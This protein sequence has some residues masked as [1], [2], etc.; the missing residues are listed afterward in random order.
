MYKNNKEQYV[1]I[2]TQDKQL[3]I[4]YKI[5]QDKKIVKQE[6]SSFLLNNNEISKDAIFKLDTL[7]KDINKTYLSTLYTDKNQVIELNSQID[8]NKYKSV[9]LNEKISVAIPTKDIE[10]SASFFQTSG[11]DYLLSPFSILNEHSNKLLSKNS[12]N[13]L[14]YN[15]MVYALI[16]DENKEI[17]KGYTQSLTPFDNIK[18][19]NFYGDD[20]VGQKL[21][22]EV[23]FLELQQVISE[24]IEKYYEDVSGDEETSFLEKL[25]IFYNVK[26]LSDEQIEMIHDLVMIDINYTPISI[27]ES[28]DN[29]IQKPTVAN[30]SFL[31]ARV[32]KSTNSSILWIAL[33]VMTILTIGGILFYKISNTQED[34]KETKTKVEKVKETTKIE[35][36]EIVETVIKL[37]NHN[38]LNTKVL[39]RTLMF[40][41]LIPFD[42][43]L[44]ELELRKN[45]S[46]FVC[47]FAIDSNASQEM[48]KKLSKI[49]DESKIILQHNNKA[50]IST[51]I[52]NDGYKALK[53]E[54]SKYTKL[55]Y[56][57]HEFMTIS[58]FTEYL[59]SI[60]IK[61]SNV[62]YISKIQEKFITYNYNITSLVNTP[63]EFFDFIAK[64]NKKEIPLN[65]KYPVEFAKVKDKI[66]IK[67]NLQ[68]HQQK[69]KK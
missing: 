21:Y 14:L 57:K 68:F 1:N 41:D 4:D 17:N 56:Q 22:E 3:K 69:K 26:Q 54:K 5:L 7:Q 66:E 47:N 34:I 20:I 58:K 42:A 28:F 30:Y 6:V 44:L 67:F 63:K 45:S 31:S 10:R 9:A 53:K 23:Y 50:I 29:L 65:I 43:V 8:K 62:K 25:N 59:N 24:I 15:N 61:D 19:S 36:K 13:I 46:T 60:V 2:L 12:L 38:L 39:E 27:E 18:D 48:I 51:I 37:P 33:L 52:S 64:L 11:L 55:K 49:Y 16:L 40:F 35:K 32:K